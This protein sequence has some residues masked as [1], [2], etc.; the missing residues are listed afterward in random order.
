VPE[1]MN[2]GEFTDI[3]FYDEVVDVSRN[4]LAADK[5]QE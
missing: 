4:E 2:I 5:A 3:M 1:Q